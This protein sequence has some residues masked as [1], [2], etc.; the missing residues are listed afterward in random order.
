MS[1]LPSLAADALPPRCRGRAGAAIVPRAAEATA[2][3][4][5]PAP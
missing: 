1:F 4:A 5:P 2:A 3:A